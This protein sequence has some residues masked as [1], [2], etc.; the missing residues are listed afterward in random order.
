MNIFAHKTPQHALKN[1]ILTKCKQNDF[2]CSLKE[3]FY[4]NRKS[5]FYLINGNC[6]KC[7]KV[8]LPGLNFNLVFSMYKKFQTIYRSVHK[9]SSAFQ[10]SGKNC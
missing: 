10:Y 8:L 5:H 3:N 6:W 7:A 4:I 9:N 1:M 2:Y